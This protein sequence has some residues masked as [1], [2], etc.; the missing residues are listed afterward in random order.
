MLDILRDLTDFRF[1]K[2]IRQ[3]QREYQVPATISSAF[4]WESFDNDDQL[5]ELTDGK[6]VG[7]IYELTAIPTEGQGKHFIHDVRLQLSQLIADTFPRYDDIECPWIVSLYVS[8][9]VGLDETLDKM[10]NYVNDRARGTAYSRL[11]LRWWKRHCEALSSKGGLFTDPLTDLPA[12]GCSR[13]T[14]MVIYRNIT[15]KATF[16]GAKNARQELAN[17]TIRLESQLKTAQI[18]YARYSENEFYQW[19]TKWVSPKPPGYNDVND[20]LRKN[21]LPKEDEKPVGYDLTQAIF[22]STPVSNDEEGIWSFDG[23]LHKM[24]P[25]LGFRKIPE[26]GVLTAEKREGKNNKAP[27]LA[28]FDRFPEGSVFVMTMVLQNEDQI[29]KR[30]ERVEDRAKKSA[31]TDAEITVKEAGSVKI[32]M[33]EK[34]YLFPTA[35]ALYIKAHTEQELMTR[36]ATVL[37]LLG[38][39]GFDPLVATNDLVS[40]DAYLRFLPFNYNYEY[41][42]RSLFRSRLCSLKQAASVF[43][44]YGRSTGTGHPGYT[45]FNRQFEAVMFDLIAD[46]IN[47]AHML[48][49]GTTGSGKSAFVISCL[50]QIMAMRF[51]RMTLID[52]GASLR[53]LV[54]LWKELGIKVNIIEIQMKRP[55]FALN[56]FAETLALLKQLCNIEEQISLEA[57]EVELNKRLLEVTTSASPEELKQ[58]DD[59]RRDYLLDFVASAIL[60]I[61]GADK[62]ELEA[63]T[64]Q[65]RY[66]II[67]AVKMAANGAVAAGFDEMIPSDLADAFATLAEQYAAQGAVGDEQAAKRMKTMEHGL[68]TFFESPINNWYFNQRGKPLPEADVTWLELGMFKDDNPENVAPR[69]LTFISL[70]NRT[71]TMAETHKNE[72]RDFIFFADEC[73]ILT[74]NA[75]TAASVVQCAKMSRKLGL[76]IWLATQNVKDFPDEAKKIVSMMEYLFVLWCDVKE[77]KDILSF[78]ELTQEQ[79]QMIATLKKESG[80][81]ME[82]ALIC[83]RGSYLFRNIPPREILAIAGTDGEEN[84][85]RHQLSHDYQC[86]LVEASLLM[87]QKYRGEEYDLPK[88]REELCDVQS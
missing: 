24:I 71:M 45:A 39:L 76:W 14:R 75:M 4:T 68:R 83:N 13:R 88:I 86:S 82:N 67:E 21:P 69:A 61:T 55:D 81:F 47:N 37:G 1:A 65:D 57:Y 87:A 40:I 63:I 58:D 25:I 34:N 32:M 64:R 19:M 52:A 44:I 11:Y 79:Q 78:R 54:N 27:Y 80:K 22:N 42:K 12:Q 51:P 6:S 33:A 74:N 3:A 70:M 29:A 43:P 77:R 16:L 56:P 9:D 20:Y 2:G 31:T 84:K 5:M 85:L 7:A 17:I 36:N 46:R 62:K 72:G 53:Q 28:S 23:I 8:D 48:T 30:I 49:F 66:F 38:G 73:H 59:A 60:M 35:M 26:D 10:E 18:G 15:K 50:A 41:D